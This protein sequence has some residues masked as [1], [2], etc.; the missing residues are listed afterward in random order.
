MTG[1][2]RVFH[3]CAKKFDG[4]QQVQRPLGMDKSLHD[5]LWTQTPIH[6][7]KVK[8]LGLSDPIGCLGELLLSGPKNE[9]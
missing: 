4:H 5:L 1:R 7:K 3:H 6:N 2:N 9:I 8:V